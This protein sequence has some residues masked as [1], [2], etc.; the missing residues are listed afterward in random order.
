MTHETTAPVQSLVDELIDDLENQADEY[1]SIHA[2]EGDLLR[3][4]AGLIRQ[5]QAL[6]AQHGAPAAVPDE[7]GL[8]PCPFCGGKAELH[9]RETESLWSHN[10]VTWSQVG[11]RECECVGA[12]CCEDDDGSEAV[13]HWNTRAADHAAP[14]PPAQQP[15]RLRFPTMLRKMWSGGEVQAWLDEQVPL[16]AAP[17]AQQSQWVPSSKQLPPLDIPVW[18]SDEGRGVFIGMRSSSTD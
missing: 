4:A 14:T 13:A 9:Q 7:N 11:C 1:D 12:D 3:G 6:I 18:L 5:Q 8:L 16:Y 17:P 15:V 10:Q 2:G